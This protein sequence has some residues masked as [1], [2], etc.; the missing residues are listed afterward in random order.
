MLSISQEYFKMFHKGQ[1]EWTTE[2]CS[3]KMKSTDEP[4]GKSYDGLQT[5]YEEIHVKKTHSGFIPLSLSDDEEEA[6]QENKIAKVL[7]TS[8]QEFSGKKIMSELSDSVCNPKVIGNCPVFTNNADVVDM[9]D[10]NTLVRE[11]KNEE[12]IDMYSTSKAFIGPI[13]K[14]EA[15]HQPDRRKKALS[16]NSLE[17]LVGRRT[18]KK[19][20]PKQTAPCDVSKIEDELSQFYSEINQL[21]HDDY[22]TDFPFQETEANSHGHPVEYNKLNH[23]VCVSPQDWPLSRIPAD[24]GGQCFYNKSSDL[25]TQNEQYLYNDPKGPRIDNGQ[26]FDGGKVWEAERLCN[27]QAGSRFWNDQFK[28]GWQHTPPFIIPYGPP[29]PQFTPYFNFTKLNSLSH[30]SETFYSSNVGPF[31]NRHVNMSNSVSDQNSEY[32]SHF[33]TPSTEITQNGYNVPDGQMDNGF[34]ETKTCW[35][36]LKPSSSVSHPFPD[37]NLCDSQKILIILRGLPGSG[38]TTLSR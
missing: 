11:H 17:V 16:S 34:C 24:G 36:D 35:K 7:N 32:A 25:R 38:K 1:H 15:D 13:Y 14:S 31:E 18:K 19:M 12:G 30:Q 9:R 10:N 23:I 26:C 6:Q 5:L 29:P 22:S 33:G 3:K 37:S 2:P 20:T 4:Y 27:K 28:P 21:E 8:K